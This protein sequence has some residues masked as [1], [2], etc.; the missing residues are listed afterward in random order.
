MKNFNF[1]LSLRKIKCF[2]TSWDFW[3]S[4]IFRWGFYNLDITS[5]RLKS[6]INV[7]FNLE[8]YF[9]CN[10]STQ[11]NVSA[12]NPSQKTWQWSVQT[13]NLTLTQHF[14]NRN[15]FQLIFVLDRARSKQT[16]KIKQ[17][18]YSVEE[19]EEKHFKPS[20]LLCEQ[21]CCNKSLQRARKCRNTALII[22]MVS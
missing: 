11:R 12:T 16:L 1:P 2:W 5:R 22:A 17:N 9:A 7:F 15:K 3:S 19:G 21:Q 14:W 8:F 4:A 13:L 6:F 10:F 20:R 18:S